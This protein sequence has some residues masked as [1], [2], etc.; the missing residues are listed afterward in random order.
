MLDKLKKDIKRIKSIICKVLYDFNHGFTDKIPELMKGLEVFLID[1]YRESK[2][3]EIKIAYNKAEKARRLL[4]LFLKDGDLNKK[5]EIEESL[6]GIM[7]LEDRLEESKLQIKI[8]NLKEFIPGIRMNE[9]DEDGISEEIKRSGQERFF[10]R[11][12]STTYA[13]DTFEYLVENP[14]KVGLI[15]EFIKNKVVVDLGAGK[16]PWGYYIA[17]MGMAKAYIAVEPYYHKEI[18]ETIKSFLKRDTPG[19]KKKIPYCIIG[20]DMLR[21]LYRLPKNSVSIFLFGIDDIII[22]NFRYKQNMN[23]EIYR[24]LDGAVVG[25]HISE[26]MISDK[27]VLIHG[28]KKG[29]IFLEVYKK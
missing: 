24:V 7:D 27:L 13:H 3:E 22:E 17:V 5:R 11:D 23:I 19:G 16:F 15:E 14:K 29:E 20:G 18:K 21:F 8:S 26:E 9:L 10:G 1:E 25:Y 4:D 6:E 2:L 28:N 12:L